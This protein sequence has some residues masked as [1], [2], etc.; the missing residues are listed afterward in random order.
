M[1][2]VLRE[3]NEAAEQKFLSLQLVNDKHLELIN[4]LYAQLEVCQ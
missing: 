4:D 1:T 3:Q 2:Q